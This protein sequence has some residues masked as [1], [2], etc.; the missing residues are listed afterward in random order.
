MHVVP[1][2]RP[3]VP[4]PCCWDENWNIPS[5]AGRA[6]NKSRVIQRTLGPLGTGRALKN[7]LSLSARDGHVR[8]KCKEQEA[9]RSLGRNASKRAV[10]RGG[11]APN[12][13]SFPGFVAS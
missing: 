1:P 7:L 12:S 11:F 2:S 4:L 13:A 6:L 8:G 10:I 9:L 3:D 5:V